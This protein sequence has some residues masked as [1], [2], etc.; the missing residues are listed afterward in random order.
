MIYL[1]EKLIITKVYMNNCLIKRHKNKKSLIK[2][3]KKNLFL[4]I[5]NSLL[6]YLANMTNFT[7]NLQILK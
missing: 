4:I 6:V 7:K 2:R 5:I 3:N 1:I